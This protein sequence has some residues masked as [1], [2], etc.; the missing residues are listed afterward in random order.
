[1]VGMVPAASAFQAFAA[2]AASERA[3]AAFDASACGTCP[4]LALLARRNPARSDPIAAALWQLGPGSD[5]FS[6]SDHRPPAR[7]EGG[8]QVLPVLMDLP[9][10][11]RSAAVAEPSRNRRGG[12][13]RVAMRN[14]DSWQVDNSGPT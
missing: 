3:M 10:H 2:V 5:G 12:P 13:K 14:I 1:M 4:S 7:S 11:R 6:W 8:V 9:S